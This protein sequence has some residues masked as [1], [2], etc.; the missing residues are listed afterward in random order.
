M[1]T[2][3]D[4]MQLIRSFNTWVQHGVVPADIKEQLEFLVAGNP[5]DAI[6]QGSE[7]LYAHY[8]LLDADGKEIMG[9]L[10]AFADRSQ[11]SRFTADNRARLIVSAVRRDLGEPA[12]AEGWPLPADA[13][14]PQ[15]NR[16]KEELDWR[17]GIPVDLESLKTR[18]RTEIEAKRRAVEEGGAPTPKGVLDS[19]ER[20]QGRIGRLV[21]MAQVA[22]A[23]SQSFNQMVT[24]KDGS[25]ALHNADEA[26][27]MGVAL[28]QHVVAAYEV[29]R[30]LKAEVA[31]ADTV[32]EV[33]A[34]D[35]DGAPWPANT[36]PV[37]EPV[38]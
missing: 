24:F 20:S 10:F 6:V 13:P 8:D 3:D 32:E 12:P 14:E 31:A 29:A 11:W 2:F 36:A 27:M 17:E 37:P 5:A 15:T 19:D 1:R 33:E 26:V 23:S 9:A 25:E 18:K 34:V 30:A 4:H 28:G 35:V 22:K 16:R 38:V 7:L 21:Q